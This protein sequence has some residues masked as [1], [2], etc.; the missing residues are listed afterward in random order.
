M[1]TTSNLGIT[2]LENS[3]NQPEVVVNTALTVV[4]DV[5]SLAHKMFAR[6]ASATTGLT[7]GYYGGSMIVDGVL[8][9]TAN[10]TLT[11]SASTTNYVE[12]TRAGVV[13]SNTTG[14]T[15][16]RF[17]IRQVV[18]GTSTISSET[19]RRPWARTMGVNLFAKTMSDANYTMTQDESLSD[20][21][22]LSGTLTAQRDL[23]TPLVRKFYTV[24]NDTAGGF[25]VRVIG[26][27][28]SGIVI[29]NQQRATI[30]CD[31]ANFD[32]PQNSVNTQDI[33]YAASITP[34][35]RSGSSVI[36]GALTGNITVNAPTN[37][38]KGVELSIAMTQ[39][40]T[41]GRT[42]TWNAVF[43]KAA[44]GAGTASQKM[45]AVFKYDGTNWIQV[46]GP[47]TWF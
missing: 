15:A 31:G 1:A 36:V 25:P 44:D 28:G 13:S 5:S 8:V 14:F 3:T 16:N 47:V 11:L 9:T 39:D 42:I 4:D 17:P 2:L 6:R 32:S 46:G 23:I 34:N 43:K 27:S 35:I 41:G 24:Y 20:I 19:E 22:V 12:A 21:I 40:A 7:W 30:Y 26:A 33:A 45:V 37:A 38:V 29:Y 18:T 10:G